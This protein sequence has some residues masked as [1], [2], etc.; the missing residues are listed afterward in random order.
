MESDILPNFATMMQSCYGDY[1]LTVKPS[2]RISV[3]KTFTE[4]PL[5]L[6]DF[7]N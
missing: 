7:E 1:C 2:N 4:M 6:T 5:G 3:V